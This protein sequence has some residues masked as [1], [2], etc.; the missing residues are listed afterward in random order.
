MKS[1]VYTGIAYDDL[2]SQ[3]GMVS[4]YEEREAAIFGGY[5]WDRWMAQDSRDRAAVVAHLRMSTMIR[6]HSQDAID[7][8]IEL[9]EKRRKAASNGS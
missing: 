5:T 8:E 4:E 6:Q 2:R 1:G 7:R 3:I 9:R